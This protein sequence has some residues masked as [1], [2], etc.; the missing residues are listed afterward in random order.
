M[1][2][3]KKRFNKF[4]LELAEEK[5]NLIKFSRFSKDRNGSFNFLGFNYKWIVSRKGKDIINTTTSKKK[6]NASVQKIKQ[7]IKSNRD[8][9][10]RKITD[11]LNKKLKGYY[12]Y[13][14]VI[15]NRMML[16]K[17]EKIVM[18]LLYKWLNRQG[19]R[20]SFSWKEFSS[21]IREFYPLQK[22]FIETIPKEKQMEMI[23]NA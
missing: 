5:T 22:I 17:M 2:A 9:R 1:K 19:Q 16:E 12:N 21:K 18:R 8:K 15:G 6:F 10:I 13:Y 4:G 3:L 14:G 7:W 11:S 20:R 23:I